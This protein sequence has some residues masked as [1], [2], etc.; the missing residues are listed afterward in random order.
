MCASVLPGRRVKRRR[1]PT[2]VWVEFARG[3]DSWAEEG[4][5]DRAD[6][7][8]DHESHDHSDQLVPEP[9]P[10]EAAV[11]DGEAE[12]DGKDGRHEW[13]EEHRSNEGDRGVL[14]EPCG[15]DDGCG[16]YHTDVAA[17]NTHHEHTR[18]LARFARLPRLRFLPNPTPPSPPDARAGSGALEGEM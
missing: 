13:R 14:H 18:S 4:C 12:G 7:H 3:E 2:S 10:G 15:S 6:G 8:T 5:E 16:K 1:S 17:R 9:P 11:S